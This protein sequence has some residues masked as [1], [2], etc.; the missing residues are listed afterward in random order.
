MLSEYYKNPSGK[1]NYSHSKTNK[2][3]GMDFHLHEYFE[4]Y[5]F[6]SGKV[7]YFIENKVYQLHYGDLIFMNNQ[8]IHKPSVFPGEA[9]ERIVIHFDSSIVG[10]L[11][12]DDFN[13]LD[14]F[15][16]R[17]KGE[18]NRINLDNEQSNHILE[19]LYKIGQLQKSVS[20]GS[21][22]IKLTAFLDLLVYINR[23]YNAMQKNCDYSDI[24]EKLRLIM[25][26]I[27]KNAEENL[28]L[29]ALGK[30]FFI[31][32]YYLSRLFKKYTGS[33]IHDYI[34]YKRI[35]K[36]KRVLSEGYSATEA[37]AVCGFNDYSNFYRMFKKTVGVSPSRYKKKVNF[38]LQNPF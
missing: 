6:I 33:N 13:L 7:N 10:L 34:L 32:K 15:I 37:S 31:D 14:C 12:P 3:H 9:Y 30:K 5:F 22:I 25:D 35:S 23:I 24:P 8:E 16:N 4:I 19:F 36:A 27:D 26:Y 17:P 21:S 11:S 18:F 29:D 20:A 2:Y 38:E 1:I 28:S